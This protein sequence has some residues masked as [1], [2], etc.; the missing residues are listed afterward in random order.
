MSKLYLEVNYDS[1][2]ELEEIITTITNSDID[3]K[4]NDKKISLL[5]KWKYLL[6]PFYLFYPIYYLIMLY[7]N[8]LT[9]Y[10]YEIGEKIF[11]SVFVVAI[12]IGII[13]IGYRLSNIQ[14]PKE[15]R[16]Y[17]ICYDKNHK[18]LDKHL[19]DYKKKLKKEN[20]LTKYK[21]RK[22]D[23]YIKIDKFC[24]VD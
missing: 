9:E 8:W 19:V 6:Y 4:I 10:H 14:A 18:I 12:C 16:E 3:F 24:K 13:F 22:K 21:Q 11:A 17:L 2:E 23:F 15:Y 20:D 1:D 5:F 7:V